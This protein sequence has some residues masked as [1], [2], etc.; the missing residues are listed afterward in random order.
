MMRRTLFTVVVLAVVAAVLSSG[1]GAQE[2]A[3]RQFIIMGFG[4]M[5]PGF[6]A[7]AMGMGGAFV[8]VADD[9]TA[10]YW[11]PAGLA[12]L[13]QPELSLVAATIPT[14]QMYGYWTWYDDYAL[15]S[16]TSSEL[17]RGDLEI[18]YAS[19]VWPR[20]TGDRKSA[21]GFS[22][23]KD[24]KLEIVQT[25]VDPYGS[26]DWPNTGWPPGTDEF[27]DRL[28]YTSYGLAYAQGTDEL[29]WGLHLRQ[30]SC[31]VDSTW[32]F[33]PT[34]GLPTPVEALS[35]SDTGTSLIAGVLGRS[36]DGRNSW[37]LTYRSKG[38]ADPEA[39]GVEL[40]SSWALGF[41][42][43]SGNATYACSAEW[44]RDIPFLGVKGV[45]AYRAGAEWVKGTPH[46]ALALRAGLYWKGVDIL[47]YEVGEEPPI[48]EDLLVATAGVGL[49]TED[50]TI[51]G[52]LEIGSEDF[53]RLTMSVAKAF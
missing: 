37:G 11:N 10:T 15:S 9:A 50:W 24:G 51:D 16:L 17:N 27:E 7:R 38:G 46:G 18:Q 40:P 52:A 31:K 5:N 13:E 25:I 3:E 35:V 44:F 41:A 19:V 8:A 48:D 34:G 42:T 4:V 49:S 47:A 6:G 14:L 26:P 29:M 45:A 12:Q 39:I 23:T 22:F 33:T 30:S 20:R 43:R 1:A 2:A 32:V 53:Q 28:T 36:E 21:L